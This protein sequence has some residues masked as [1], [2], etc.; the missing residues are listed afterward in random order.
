LLRETL[1]QPLLPTIGSA[2]TIL[3]STD[4][5][6]GELP[7]AALPGKATNTFLIED[8]RLA[9]IP[10]PKLL[11]QLVAADDAQ[12]LPA[13]LLT[14][15][16]LDYDHQPSKPDQPTPPI[17]DTLSDFALAAADRGSDGE[18]FGR[19][20]DT[21]RE[22]EAVESLMRKQLRQVDRPVVRLEGAAA[23]KERVVLE[24]SRCE[25]LHLATHGFFALARFKSAEESGAERPGFFGKSSRSGTATFVGFAPGLLSGLVLSGANLPPVP[26][27]DDGILTAEEIACLPLDRVRLATLSAC[28]TGLG[29]RAGGEG[30]LGIQRAFQV[31]GVRSTVASYW[32]VD[33][34]VTRHFM[35]L[36]YSNLWEKKLPALDSLREA[37]LQ[38]LRQPDELRKLAARGLDLPEDAPQRSSSRFW[39]A[40]TLSG[41][42][43]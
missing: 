20:P 36:F 30:L 41:D 15:G 40:F 29:K 43:R 38:L 25:H 31:S 32:K 37:Q 1:W 26:G 14:L 7:L 3:V 9:M 18:H 23:S 42:W 21:L 5:V 22:I 34:A 33:D 10:V 28:E 24:M 4:G 17:P 27:G 8:Y 12:P 11:P 13:V 6:L 2:K 35:E 19:L 39:A 16:N